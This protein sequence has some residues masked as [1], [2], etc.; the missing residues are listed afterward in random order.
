MT[1]LPIK[2]TPTKQQWPA[3]YEAGHFFVSYPVTSVAVQ[4][5]VPLVEYKAVWPY[6]DIERIDRCATV[7]V[8]NYFARTAERVGHAT[9]DGVIL[10]VDT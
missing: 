10:R 2:L 6:T 8:T 5:L 4:K 1:A 9:V 3:S 7:P